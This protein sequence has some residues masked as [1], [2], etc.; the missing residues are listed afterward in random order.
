MRQRTPKGPYPVHT[1]Y[2]NK[3]FCR[4]GTVYDRCRFRLCFEE[5]QIV[6]DQFLGKGHLKG[7]KECHL[8]TGGLQKQQDM[9]GNL[10]D[11]TL[12]DITATDAI[13]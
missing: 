2:T 12:D 13:A 5:L 4:L 7:I 11:V 9:V 6:G 3:M 8:E 1:E 10:V